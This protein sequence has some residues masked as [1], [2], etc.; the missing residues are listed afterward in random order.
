MRV[1]AVDLG[2]F[3][4]ILLI[5]DV[6]RGVL[7]PL[8]EE[9]KTVDL[10]YS[11]AGAISGRAVGRAMR[12]VRRF[13]R[14][15]RDHQV[16]CGLVVA[17]AAMRHASNRNTVLQELRTATSLPIKT[18]SVRQEANF[19]ARGASFGLSRIARS[20]LVVDIGG[21]SSEFIHPKTHIFRGL[22]IGAAWA[23]K[24]WGRNA[25]RDR[26]KRGLYFLASSERAVLGL[27]IRRFGTIEGVI[28]LGGTITTL[29]AINKR[30][31]TF[32]VKS[33]HGSI[34]TADWIAATGS[35]MAGLSQAALRDLVPFDTSRARVLLAGT[36]LWSAV[37]NRL[38]TDR[39]T[40]SARGLRWGV[41]AHL[42]GLP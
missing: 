21:G 35:E 27:D 1:A 5:A 10:E 33:V 2:T 17:T 25:P 8:H 42:A 9:R 38:N 41:A 12:A 16:D 19:S 30:M 31:R 4:A 14:I 18:I 23:T 40:V 3:S 15:S 7:V 6:K 32:E 20:S 37:L 34:L 26:A 36:Y 24:A 39:V 22:S 28:G 29:A 13:D 11:P